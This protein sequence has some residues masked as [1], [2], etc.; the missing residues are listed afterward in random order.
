M[1][2]AGPFPG[3]SEG[4]EVRAQ[5]AD[6]EHVAV[7]AGL[8]RD[9]ELAATVQPG[10]DRHHRHHG[11]VPGI[12]QRRRHADLL[13]E[14]DQVARGRERQLEAAGFPAF[15]RL[16]RRHPDRVGGFL[17]VMG[18]DLRGRCGGEEEPGVEALGHAF[19]RDP[20]RIG[21][22]FVE[23][24]HHAVVGQHLEKGGVAVAEVGAV[25]GLDLAGFPGID[26]RFFPLRPRQQD[27]A[28]LKSFADRGDAEAQGRFI[29][30]LPARIKLRR[31]DDFL[32][33]LVDAAARK[34]QGAGIEVD[35]IMANHHEDLDLLQ[36]QH[37]RAATGWW[38]QDAE[39]R[40]R[41]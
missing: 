26:Q 9:P 10:H 40:F 38:T 14:L 7:I 39:R 13:A 23:R 15:Q 29:E 22:E 41:P 17:A 27:A 16:A 35:F 32:V 1:L 6:L 20:V 2:M 24:Q 21:H 34:H 12:I 28:F 3:Y 5:R 37:C 30:P 19:G 25:R 11:L 8:E 33:A 31:G 36:R 4:P 18:A